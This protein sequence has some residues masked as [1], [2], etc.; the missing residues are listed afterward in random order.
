MKNK[1]IYW[2]KASIKSYTTSIFKPT[3][4]N[5]IHKKF[6]IELQ[7]IAYFVIWVKE[8][9]YVLNSEHAPYST[10]W[11]NHQLLLIPAMTD[12]VDCWMLAQTQNVCALP[13]LF[14]VERN[15]SSIQLANSFKQAIA[16][17]G[18]PCKVKKKVSTVN[19]QKEILFHPKYYNKIWL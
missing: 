6:I 17:D 7:F 5:L 14:S 12:A 19:E 9:T 13:K 10:E 8:V 4:R 16:F 3:V 11:Y 1:A 18:F 15:W 2:W